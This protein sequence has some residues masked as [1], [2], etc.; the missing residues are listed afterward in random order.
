MTCVHMTWYS[1]DTCN[2]TQNSSKIFPFIFQFSR[3]SSLLRRWLLDERCWPLKTFTAQV[4]A[5]GAW[6][7]K[8]RSVVLAEISGY[9]RCPRVQRAVWTACWMRRS[10]IWRNCYA[11]YAALNVAVCLSLWY[12]SISISF[13]YGLLLNKEPKFVKIFNVFSALTVDAIFRSK[14]LMPRLYRDTCRPETCIM[15]AGRATCIRMHYADGHMSPIQVVRPG[16]LWSIS[17]AT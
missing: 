11:S 16:Y 3:Q 13:S 12:L 6:D 8:M 2:I 14:S 7:R 10:V 15:Y 17:A 5:S 9:N 4:S 1:Y